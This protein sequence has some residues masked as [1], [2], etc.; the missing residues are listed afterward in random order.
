[1]TD[2]RTKSSG[3]EIRWQL[4]ADLLSDSA[5]PTQLVYGSAGDLP[6]LD[7]DPTN[8]NK[9]LMAA[10]NISGILYGGIHLLA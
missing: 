9:A 6:P 4:A 3:Y 1:M 5:V 10:F 7:I 2:M 8:L